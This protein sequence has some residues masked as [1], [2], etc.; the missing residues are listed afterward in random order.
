MCFDVAIAETSGNA[1][2][3]LARATLGLVLVPT[4]AQFVTTE[5]ATNAAIEFHQRI[6]D[7][8]EEGDPDLAALVARRHVEDF[9]AAWERSG[10]AYD[11]DISKL[12]DDTT[13]RLDG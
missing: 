10:L 4:V 7:A 1:P 3:V 6:Y 11:C 8:I 12:I 13:A 9:A 2:L 5:R